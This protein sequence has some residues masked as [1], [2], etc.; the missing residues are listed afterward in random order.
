M[1]IS[2]EVEEISIDDEKTLTNSE[3]NKVVSFQN[4]WKLNVG[5][6]ENE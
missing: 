5:R 2:P 1:D 4:K 3:Q 6:N